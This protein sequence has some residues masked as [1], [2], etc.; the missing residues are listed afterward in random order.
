[1]VFTFEKCV[2]SFHLLQVIHRSIFWC[3]IGYTKIESTTFYLHTTPYFKSAAPTFGIVRSNYKVPMYSQS[4]SF[5]Y[6]FTYMVPLVDG[7]GN[8]FLKSI[9]DH[10]CQTKSLSEGYLDKCS[11]ST[12]M[13]FVLS[14]TTCNF[15][16]TKL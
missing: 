8:I 12:Q 10:M 11:Y 5:L 2:N 4:Y 14:V 1:M 3:K 13:D 7:I 9:I 6:T 16:F 15:P